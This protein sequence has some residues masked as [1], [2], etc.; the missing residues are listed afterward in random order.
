MDL[1]MGLMIG[2]GLSA[3]CGF[4]VFVPIL[5]MSIANLAGHLTL[6]SGFEWIGTW[7]TLIGFAVIDR[8]H[9]TL[10]IFEKGLIHESTPKFHGFA[11][12]LLFFSVSLC[13]CG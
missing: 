12:Y 9:H 10:R 8:Q 6:S 13:L 5:G 1:L 4:R 3:A 7:P 2:V 11:C